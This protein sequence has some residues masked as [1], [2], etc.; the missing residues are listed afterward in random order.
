VAGI[1]YEP[2]AGTRFGFTYRSKLTYHF[3]GDAT[4][5]G[6]PTPFAAVFPN[7]AAR[8]SL[9]TPATLSLHAMQDWGAWR[10][11]A[12]ATWW[13]FNSFKVL[14]V[15]FENPLTP[16]SSKAEDW[17]NA[18]LYSVGAAYRW[19]E[20]FTLRFGAAYNTT[21]IPSAERR[22]PR[23]PD[24]NRT[25]LSIGATWRPAPNCDVHVGYAHLFFA[26]APVDDLDSATHHLVGSFDVSADVLSAQA[27]LRF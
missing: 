27:T 9:T 22:T 19:N 14:A 23:I 20:H 17:K 25:W 8:A 16:D 1:L 21:P 26:N 7:Q 5:T 10:L 18:G 13:R 4:F 2:V 24:A 3:V 6:V 12:E 15:D 11:T